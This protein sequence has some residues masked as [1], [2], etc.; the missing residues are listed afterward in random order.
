MTD[1]SQ[2][3]SLTGNH[4]EYFEIINQ[5]L[6]F[7]FL[8]VEEMSSCL[9]MHVVLGCNCMK[10]NSLQHDISNLQTLQVFLN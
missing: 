8:R 10:D 1:F 2:H 6:A 4:F 7:N 9:E 5:C 3:D